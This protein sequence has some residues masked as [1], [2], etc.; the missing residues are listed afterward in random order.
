MTGD[1]GVSR[2]FAQGWDKQIGP[3][4]LSLLGASNTDTARRTNGT[5]Q[6]SNWLERQSS[7]HQVRR[8]RQLF[9]QT[10]AGRDCVKTPE[11]L[12]TLNLWPP[13]SVGVAYR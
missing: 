3:P 1:F 2:V 10:L 6:T 8:A 13:H 5:R 4:H 7:K 9:A 11:L 12:L